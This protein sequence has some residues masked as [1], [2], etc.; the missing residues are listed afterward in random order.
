VTTKEVLP[1]DVVQRRRLVLGC[2]R[3]GLFWGA[4]VGVVYV[5]IGTGRR[6][7]AAKSARD[8]LDERFARGDLNETEYERKRAVLEGRR[9]SVASRD[10]SP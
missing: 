3:D 7:T 9:P 8:A 5:L 4:I 10:G 1:R 2:A 6:E